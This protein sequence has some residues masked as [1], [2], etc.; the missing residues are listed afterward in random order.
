MILAFPLI[1]VVSLFTERKRIGKAEERFFADREPLTDA[2]YTAAITNPLHNDF[3]FGARRAMATLC[4]TTPDMIHPSDS[5]RTLLDL[6][7]DSGYIQD[8]VFF[9]EQ[10]TSTQIDLRRLPDTETT[11]FG[12][13]VERLAE[14]NR[15]PAA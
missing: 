15:I 3:H 14:G 6:Q 4:G 11:T 1:Y 10:E 5:M 13:F 9:T 12:D 2:Q 7:F 8:F